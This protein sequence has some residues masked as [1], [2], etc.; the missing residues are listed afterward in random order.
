MRERIAVAGAI[1]GLIISVS[2]APGPQEEGVGSIAP[3]PSN[4][5]RQEKPSVRVSAA[6]QTPVSL[7]TF[8]GC[9]E[10]LGH[11]RARAAAIVGPHG[12]ERGDV[13]V[14]FDA[15]AMT[16]TA[17]R[18]AA[19]G[20]P[21][22]AAFVLSGEAPAAYSRTNVQVAG[23][24]E[25]D[26][27][28][29]D[30]RAIFWLGERTLHAVAVEH[31]G[32]MR[33]AGS[34]RLRGSEHTMLLAGDRLI[35][36]GQGWRAQGLTGSITRVTVVDASDVTDLRIVSETDFEGAF[37][38]ARLIDGT[39][40]IVIRSLQ[41]N[42]LPFRGPM[43]WTG[44]DVTAAI[45]RN[46]R[47]LERS[48]DDAWL[49]HVATGRDQTRSVRPLVACSDVYAPKRFSGLDMVSIV[50][51]DPS[52]PADHHTASVLG[53]GDTVYATAQRLF[54]ATTRFVPQSAQ[55]GFNEIWTTQ[56]HSFDIS[57]PAGAVYR[58]SGEVDGQLKSQWALDL[59]EGSLR[60]ATTLG[61]PWEESSESAVATLQERD[62][63]LEQ[64]GRVGGL[65][66]RGEQIYAVRFIGDVGY[67][68]TFRLIDPLYTIDLSDPTDPR[69]LGALK[70]PG[71]SAY[72]HPV[73]DGLLIGIGQAA[74]RRGVTRGTQVS[75]FDVSDPSDPQ[76]IDQ[77]HFD[78][79][80]SEAE[81][82]HHAFLYWPQT[83]TVVVPLAE[84]DDKPFVGAVG[85]RLKDRTLT[86]IGRVSHQR[87]TLE[88]WLMDTWR[89]QIRRSLV[90]GDVLYTV[91][92]LGVAANS[93][94]SFEEIGWVRFPTVAQGPAPSDV[95]GIGRAAPRRPG[96]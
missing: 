89:A 14:V 10:L 2:V 52:D 42:G 27:V 5:P 12:L 1:V 56:I 78:T 55:R 79:G 82:E 90:V 72:L 58:A 31:D 88:R 48:G 39:A 44:P 74:T 11:V 70:I 37:V 77:L 85:I 68:V 36:F 38:S 54:V 32:S 46:K 93:L 71:Y 16:G 86:E 49:P 15:I 34:L 73:D 33:D 62:G 29:T 43:G 84:Y 17:G 69:V 91:S 26:I 28:K 61:V 40:R 50:T 59:H 67:V 80:Y 30:G 83:G 22:P 25:P 57:D 8:S 23:V 6:A 18:G 7:R 51:M 64:V 60:V 76:R 92:E 81:S 21:A 24:D 45:E 94:T 20:V 13:G 53:G 41:P 66:E 4:A 96:G 75:L 95:G 65:G 9:G 87:G 3:P 63:V 47:V 19:A 35:V